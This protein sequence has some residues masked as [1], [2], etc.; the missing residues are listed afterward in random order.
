MSQDASRRQVVVGAAATAA[1]I[2]TS[3]KAATSGAPIAATKAGKV[4]GFIDDGIKV[5]LGVRYGADTATTRFAA[6]KPPRPW[7]GVRDALKHGAQ[8]PQ[9]VGGSGEGGGLF[10]SWG[11]T[12]PTMSEDCLF[13]NVW[14][15]ALKDGKKRPVMLWFH[16][17]GFAAGSG[18]STA[19]EGTRLCQRGDVVVVTV[20]HR[21][22]L[23]G[24]LYLAQYGEQFADSGNAGILDLVLAMQWVAD[25]AAEF[26]GDPDNVTIFGES[27]GGA[28]VSTLMAMDAAKG[29]F[30]RAAVQSGA[31]LTVSPAANASAASAKVVEKLGLTPETIDQIRAMPIEKI[32]AAAAGSMAGSG[33]VVDGRNLA[34]HPFTPDAPAQS[35]DVPL[36]I[37]LNRTESTLLIG[38]RDPSLFDLSWEALPGKLNFM[39]PGL[40]T[41]AIIAEY[42]RLHPKHSPSDV[43]FAA[44]TDSRFLRGHV[45]EAERQAALGGAPVYFYVLEWETPV[46]G[47]KWRSPHALEIGFVFDNVA[48]SESM[49]GVGPD[50]QRIADLMSEAWL[51]FARTGNPNNRL[52]P[53]WPAYDAAKRASLVFD[54]TPTVV[55]DWHG[56]ERALFSKL[57]MGP[58][59]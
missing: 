4:K 45:L 9:P 59:G 18:A 21:L 31:W 11:P 23:F 56:A 46:D 30:H 28:K 7:T 29:L 36:L 20:N 53:A 41:P 38:S 5:F 33:P 47:G 10:K 37:G 22:N 6:P 13:L 27:G 2:S 3:A 12:K 58:T 54:L 14:T 19:Y 39:L 57:P 1:A 49:S 48:K 16:G 34:R 25:N 24:H 40:D 8:A 17:G 15:P 42:R 35:K 50:Q 43:F 44:T 51:A 26:G 52:L 32:Q 55:E